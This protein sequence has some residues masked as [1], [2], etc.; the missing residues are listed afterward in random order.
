MVSG[1]AKFLKE[2]ASAVLVL[3]HEDCTWEK[4]EDYAI[5]CGSDFDKRVK[6]SASS[7]KIGFNDSSKGLTIAKNESDAKYMM[8]FKVKN[9][10]RHMSGWGWGRFYI[11]V[12]GSIVVTNIQSGEVVCVM[13]VAVDGMPDYVEDDRI[14]KAFYAVGEEL[15]RK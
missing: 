9:L 3:S 7:C 11:S 10:A 5:W 13:D 15:A 2:K 4:H 14:G 8:V 6:L 1:S 12:E